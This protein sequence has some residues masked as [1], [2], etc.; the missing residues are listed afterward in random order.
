MKKLLLLV[1]LFSCLTGT[2][3]QDL[4]GQSKQRIYTTFKGKKSTV[5]IKEHDVGK[6][7]HKVVVHVK[8][9]KDTITYIYY[10]NSK[11][12]VWTYIKLVPRTEY[13]ERRFTL[14]VL[15]ERA[16]PFGEFVDFYWHGYSQG[17]SVYSKYYFGRNRLLQLTDNHQYRFIMLQF[18]K[19]DI[20]LD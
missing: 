11:A 1:I 9:Y 12:E 18:S 13:W 15:T 3:A 7:S 19:V 10:V 2:Y 16:I 6:V 14:W 4:I 20:A 5:K 17:F 8:I